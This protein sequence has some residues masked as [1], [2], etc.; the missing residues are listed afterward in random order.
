MKNETKKDMKK[1][2][3]VDDISLHLVSIKSRLL[4]H[5]QVYPVQSAEM[6]FETL[7]NFIPDLILLDINMPTIDGYETIKKLKADDR[8]ADIPVIFLTGKS[9]KNSVM[10]G[11]S[12]G[13]ADYVTKPF[14]DQA[15]IERIENQVDPVKR[16]ANRPVILAVDDAPSILQSI[17]H[18]LQSKYKVHTLPDPENLR[19]LL[20]DITPD[21]FL[22]D[23]KMPALSGFDLIPIIREFSA[24]KKTPILIMT[25]EGTIDNISVAAH[26]G[27]CDFLVKPVNDVMLH[28][29]VSTHLGNYMMR[30]Q[31]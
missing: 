10:K 8:Y 21:L 20:N 25:S 17:H 16:E 5:Y 24:H 22:L 14:S 18:A 4:R 9:D 13:A 26:L 27:A 23:Y 30:R 3:L 28:K 1:I 29:K 11:M 15:L 19:N 12:L 6:M 2:I 31:K 7:E